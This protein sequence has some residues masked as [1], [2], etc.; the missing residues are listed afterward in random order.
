MT[1]M[2][3]RVDRSGSYRG[4]DADKKIDIDPECSTDMQIIAI[5]YTVKRGI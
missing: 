1:I 4:V 5:D 3:I 2:R